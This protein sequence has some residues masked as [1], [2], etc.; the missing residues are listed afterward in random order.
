MESREEQ[1]RRGYGGGMGERGET[2][3]EQVS[4][5]TR[6]MEIDPGKA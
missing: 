3:E 4:S 6:G 2:Q 1:E 5:S